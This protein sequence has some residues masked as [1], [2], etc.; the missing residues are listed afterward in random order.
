MTRLVFGFLKGG[1]ASYRAAVDKSNDPLAWLTQAPF[2]PMLEGSDEH[3]P[4][5]GF[6]GKPTYKPSN[7]KRKKKHGFRSRKKKRGGRK[8]LK[9][10]RKRGRKKLTVETGSK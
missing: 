7:R 2:P 9:R 8:T 6:M 10:R 5:G 4:D 1:R 3:E